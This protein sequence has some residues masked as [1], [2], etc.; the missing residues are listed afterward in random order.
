MAAP[1]RYLHKGHVDRNVE[2]GRIQAGRKGDD[3][4]GVVGDTDVDLREGAAPDG[5]DAGREA[6]EEFIDP[7]LKAVELAEEVAPEVEITHGH[8]L[9]AFT[10]RRRTGTRAPV[11]LPS[12]WQT[13]RNTQRDN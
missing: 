10:K 3:L 7:P 11:H 8:I 13:N 5:A 6:S 4:D 1:P 9:L 12:L 2:F